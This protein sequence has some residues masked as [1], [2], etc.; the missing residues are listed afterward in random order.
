MTE[1][2]ETL[3]IPS[4]MGDGFEL[5]IMHQPAAAHGAARGGVLYVHGATFPSGLA[6][7]FKLDGASWM[8]D[9]AN[10]GF[11]VWA[12]DFHG[13]GGSSR[14][15]EMREASTANGPLGRAP[16]VAEQIDAVVQFVLER[17]KRDRL[18]LI[19]HSWG[20]QPAALFASRN[21][22][23]VDRLVFFGPILRRELPNLPSPESV[24]AYRFWTVDEQWKRFVEDAPKNHAP[25]LRKQDF[26]RWAPLY[27]ATDPASETRAPRAVMTPA[28]PQADI[29][30][31]WAGAL[32]YDPATI[33]APMLVV[34]GE[35]DSLCTDADVQWLRSV[36]PDG[37]TLRDIKIPR[38]THLMH[39]EEGRVHLY[40]A[41]RE[42]LTGE[43]PIMIAGANPGVA[44]AFPRD[45]IAAVTHRD[46]Y[47]YYADLVAHKPLYRDDRMGLW[48][49]SSADAVTAVLTNNDCRVRP[50]NESV[51][52][53][54]AGSPAGEIFRRL[55]RMNDGAGH[56]PFNRAIAAVLTS[57]EPESVIAQTKLCAQALSKELAPTGDPAELT[58]FNFRLSTHVVGNLLGVPQDKLNQTA[59][60]IGEFVRCV[61]PAST[62]AQIEQGK[63]AAGHL[64]DLFRELYERGKAHSERGLSAVLALEGERV[65]RADPDTI[66]A[67]GIGLL[68]Q[69][70][71]ATAGLIGNTLLAL[72]AHPELRRRIATDAALA[73][74]LML[75]VLRYDPPTHNTR[76]FLARD[77]TVLGQGM[78]AG[79][80]ILV[81]IAAANR[82]PA[83]NPDPH[84]FDVA[85]EQRRLFTFG[86]GVHSCPGDAFAIAIAQTAVV[87]LVESGL[88]FD[89]LTDG[90]TYRPSANVR[91]PIFHAGGTHR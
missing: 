89:R 70:Y 16:V 61:F 27:L 24:P 64:L 2:Q 81:V 32:P 51:P 39:L 18:H 11:D 43:T 55:V 72:A 48:V 76:R 88:N 36:F 25:V 37:A 82:D 4:P 6:V 42:F 40:R 74:E 75:E 52:P 60:W 46:P 20:T 19:A 63:I 7:G 84:R 56:C 78:A 65:G 90:M 50:P 38:A 12:F 13:Y 69:A 44:D 68:S 71:E 14:Y 29:L 77:A 49:A 15:R 73:R 80:A 91:V 85:R 79:D 87:H 58:E 10:A 5:F 66:I 1:V 33:R 35:W 62:P 22:N 54:I 23:R 45:P 34:R 86:A 53:A 21:P 67:N 41:T 3:H 8:D 28:G 83:A 31:S 59:K 30:A 17:T 9:L 47:P 26:E 57:V